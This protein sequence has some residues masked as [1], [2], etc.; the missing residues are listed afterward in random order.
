[1]HELLSA[2]SADRYVEQ[3]RATVDRLAGRLRTTQPTVAMTD[4][5]S[6]LIYAGTLAN[7][8]A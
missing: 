6:S 4:Q 7:P 3:M 2:T 8:I 5:S 1:M